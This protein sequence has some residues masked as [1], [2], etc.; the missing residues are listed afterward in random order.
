MPRLLITGISGFAGRHLAALLLSRGNEVYG[1][2]RRADSRAALAALATRYPALRNE[3]VRIVDMSDAAAL[4]TA[5]ATVRPDG[6]FHL[7]G[8]TFVPASHA[9]P[10]AA[11]RVNVLGTIHLFA[12]VRRH[13]PSCRIVL[14]GSGDAYGWV[15]SADLPIRETCPFRPMSP[16][17][18]SKAAADLVAFQ[19]ARAYGLDIVRAR[20]FNHVGPGQQPLFVCPDF[21]RQ[22]VAVERGAQPPTIAV[23]N[24]DVVRDFSDVRD[25]VAGYAAA[26]ERGASGEAYNIASGVGRSIREMLETLIELSGL[27]VDISVSPERVRT[28]EV[29]VVIGC[30]DKLAAATGW[31]PAYAWRQTLAE[32][33]ADWRAR[34]D[35]EILA[36]S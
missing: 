29:P 22:L 26:W 2:V 27:R 5:V 19:W 35:A 7:A 9:D 1:T 25:V 30:A 34:P 13:H 6:I 33:L 11:F 20:P 16:Y 23:G 31:A 32:V 8:M 12:A 15:E 28:T 3:H 21:A 18:A 10:T 24:L 14:V 17:G 36:A 4:A